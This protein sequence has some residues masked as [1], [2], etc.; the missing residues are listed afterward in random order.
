MPDLPNV[1]FERDVH[2]FIVSFPFKLFIIITI[3]L[4]FFMYQIAIY[5]KYLFEIEF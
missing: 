4:Y 3:T 1:D 2:Q 5:K